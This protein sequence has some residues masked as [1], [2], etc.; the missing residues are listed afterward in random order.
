MEKYFSHYSE[1]E[2]S[3]DS[4]FSVTFAVIAGISSVVSI[5]NAI[6]CYPEESD[7]MLGFAACVTLSFVTLLFVLF[8]L[9]DFIRN[10]KPK[11]VKSRS[12]FRINFR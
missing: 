8:V 4:E 10:R 6:S 9:I 7:I 3:G 12:R 2:D 5:I 11:A 1:D